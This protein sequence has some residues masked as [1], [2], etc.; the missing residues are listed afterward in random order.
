MRSVDVQRQTGET[1]IEMFFNLDGEGQYDIRTDCG[2]MRHMLEL[3][4]RHS[5][6]DLSLRCQGDSYVD[7]HHTVE[8]MG[9]VLGAGFKQALGD[10]RGIARYGS[11]HLPMDEA[12]VLVAVDISGRGMVTCD[13]TLKEKVGT[14][15][16]E[17]VEEFFIAF[18]REAGITLH[19]HQLAGSNTHHIIEAAFKGFGRALA[20][21]TQV[22]GTEIPSTKGML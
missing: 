22:V 18:T 10:K 3:F 5:G 1:A 2:F 21:A 19:I 8:D 11:I 12:L 17:L 6:Y 4:T 14:F 15:D 13:L 9:I 16:T 7:D 20:M